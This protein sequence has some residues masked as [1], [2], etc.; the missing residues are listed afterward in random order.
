M[1]S[2]KRSFPLASAVL[3][4][5]QLALVSSVAARY[6]YERWTCPQVWAR[7]AAYDPELAMRGRYLSLQLTVNGCK[8]TLPNAGEAEFPRN[9]DGSVRYG[10]YGIRAPQ[11]VRFPA[12]LKVED[13]KLAAIRIVNPD[14]NGA[15][16]MVSAWPES[17]CE[18]MRLEA[19][20][21]FYIAEHAPSPLPLKP[22]QE[23]WVEV[24]VPPAGPPRPTQLALK[25]DNVWKPLAFRPVRQPR[26]KGPGTT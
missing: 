23:L 17:S 18:N 5:F 15:G 12:Q 3:L 22:G 2:S 8:S 24:T 19:P 6:L 14:A 7:S 13:N 21:N 20:V 11:P 26:G 10:P 1:K 25:Q 4:V 16:Q 9:V